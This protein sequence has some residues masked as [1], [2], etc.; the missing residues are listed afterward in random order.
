MRL[1]GRV[2]VFTQRWVP[3]FITSKLAVDS[4][5]ADRKLDRR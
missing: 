1:A 5:A 2:A 4:T 3:I